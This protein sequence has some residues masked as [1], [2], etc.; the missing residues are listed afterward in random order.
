VYAV[1]TLGSIVGAALAGL[2]LMP[3]LGLKWLLVA[4]ALVDVALGLLPL[5]A[6]VAPAE[7]P[8][9]PRP[10]PCRC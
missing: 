6:R 9:P 2:L 3:L 8:V 1:N 10:P 7:R 4:G 5:Y